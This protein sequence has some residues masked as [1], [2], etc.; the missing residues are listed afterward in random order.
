AARFGVPVAVAHEVLQR[1]VRGGR[2][3]TGRLLPESLGGSGAEYCDPEVMRQLRRRSLA[4]LRR[5]VEP[6]PQEALGVFLPRWQRLGDLRGAPG[7]LRAVEQL[8]GL[9]LPLSDLETRIL[10]ARV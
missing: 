8:A 2:L 9:P 6:V 3:L 10:P 1:L 4:A 7:L 5:E